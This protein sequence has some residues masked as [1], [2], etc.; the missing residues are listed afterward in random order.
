MGLSSDF[1]LKPLFLPLKSYHGNLKFCL[2]FR[3]FILTQPHSKLPS[4]FSFRLALQRMHRQ[5]VQ[6]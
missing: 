2:K 1:M 4:N 6:A 5:D 3:R